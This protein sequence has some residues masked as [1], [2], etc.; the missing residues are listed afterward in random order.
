MEYASSPHY[1][2]FVVTN[3]TMGILRNREEHLLLITGRTSS[4]SDS[5]SLPISVNVRFCRCQISAHEC[6][7]RSS[8]A[9]RVAVAAGARPP[10]LREMG[11]FEG[12]Q[13]TNPA[14]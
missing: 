9:L 14:G 12:T 1:R 11:R 7:L 2:G 3:L 8:D 6:V 4:N 13:M 5:G 10:Y